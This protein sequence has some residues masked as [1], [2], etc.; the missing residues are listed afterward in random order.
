M[1]FKHFAGA[2]LWIVVMVGWLLLIGPCRPQLQQEVRNEV[3]KPWPAQ[4]ATRWVE[5]PVVTL[6]AR[7]RRVAAALNEGDE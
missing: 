1:K 2:A 5:L 3:R 4:G 6:G 7:A